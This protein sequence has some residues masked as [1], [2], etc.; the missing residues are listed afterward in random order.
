MTNEYHEISQSVSPITET[1][2][3]LTVVLRWGQPEMDEI[4]RCEMEGFLNG[5]VAAT[6]D[7][8]TPRPL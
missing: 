3:L 1:A 5:V 4:L 7:T 6:V 8:G 2:I